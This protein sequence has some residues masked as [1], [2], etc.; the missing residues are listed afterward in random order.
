MPQVTRLPTTGTSD[1]SNG[2]SKAWSNPSRVTT[3][4]NSEAQ[5]NLSPGNTTHWLRAGGFDFSV[6]P[7][8]ATINTINVRAECRT[9]GTV[10]DVDCLLELPAFGGTGTNQPNAATWPTLANTYHEHSHTAAQWGGTLTGSDIKDPAFYVL[11]SAT[12]TGG[13]NAGTRIDSI[14]VVIDYTESGGTPVTIN[15][16]NGQATAA[17]Q[18]LAAT[19]PAVIVSTITA[20]TSTTGQAVAINPGTAAVTINVAN[21]QAAAAGQPVAISTTGPA[22]TIN[23][24]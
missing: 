2:G 10:L 6:I 5:A 19:G 7:D 17:G 13:S 12:N 3:S 11:I 9:N 21:G 4:D 18:P 23:V 8:T 16:T 20:T 22:V 15:V 1:G 24:A 14:E